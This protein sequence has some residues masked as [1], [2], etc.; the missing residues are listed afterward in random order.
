[1]A[2]YCNY[3][4]QR[5]T[6]SNYVFE[7]AAVSEISNLNSYERILINFFLEGL[8]MAQEGSI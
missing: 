2:V 7:S 6:T 4:R 8:S 5:R 3:L 1:M